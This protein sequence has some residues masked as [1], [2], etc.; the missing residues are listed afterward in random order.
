MHRRLRPV[1]NAFVYPVFFVQ[2]P[3][4]RSGGRQLRAFSRSTAATCSVST[5]RTTAPRDGSPLLPWIQSLLR[6]QRPAGRRRDRAAVLPA[7]VRLRLQSGQL[8]V[9]PRPCRRADRRS[10]RGQQHLRRSPQLP[11]AQ[12]GRRAAARRRR[13]CGPSKAFHVSPFCE[14]EGGYRFRFHLER[15]V[16]VARIDY[17]DAE[18][19]LLLTSISGKSTRLVRRRLARRLPAHALADRRRRLPHPL[20]GPQALAQGR[21]FRRRPSVCRPSTPSG[22]AKMNNTMILRGSGHLA[23]DTRLVFAL[24]ENLHGGMLEVRLPDGSSACSARASTA[25]R[26]RCTT[27]RCSARCWRA[28]TSVWPKPI[29]TATGIRPTSPAC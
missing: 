22:I 11:A 25:S 9:L 4:R 16:P 2:L 29:S 6:E 20:A 15:T 14:V 7:R 18:G 19:E 5:R 27:R 24:L 23:R 17:D 26:C 21:A 3:V 10:G 8:L 13:N 12:P 28:A 1:V